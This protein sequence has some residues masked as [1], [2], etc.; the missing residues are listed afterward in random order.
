MLLITDFDTSSLTAAQ[1]DAVW[2][3]VGRGGVLLF[4]TGA[5]AQEVMSRFGDELLSGPL[6]EAEER[7]VNM[8]VEF[9]E[10]SPDSATISLVCTDIYLNGGK[11]VLSSDEIMVLSSAQVGQG[12]AAAAVYDFGDIEEFCREQF[13]MWIS[14]LHPFWGGADSEHCPTV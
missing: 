2:D 1:A 8:G 4:G 3:W 6:P 13:P 11:E 5:R 14:C 9:A 12:L 10:E 7:A